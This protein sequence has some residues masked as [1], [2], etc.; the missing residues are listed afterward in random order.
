MADGILNIIVA[1]MEKAMSP[2]I[3]L[4]VEPMTAW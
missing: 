4:D 3:S 1:K 2:M